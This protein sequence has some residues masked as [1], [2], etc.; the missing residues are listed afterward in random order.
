V[1]ALAEA[2]G[3]EQLL[4]IRKLQEGSLLLLLLFAKRTSNALG[5]LPEITVQAYEK[6]VIVKRFGARA[7]LERGGDIID[8]LARNNLERAHESSSTTPAGASMV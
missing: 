7:C 4:E 6:L 3:A 2:L 8:S 1:L 5:Q